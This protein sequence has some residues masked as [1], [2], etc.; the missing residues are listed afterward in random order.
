MM[1]QSGAVFFFFEESGTVLVN[2]LPT[3]KQ[4]ST[5]SSSTIHSA[6]KERVQ[7]HY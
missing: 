2:K 5:S 3:C 7:L 1:V 6:T 4:S